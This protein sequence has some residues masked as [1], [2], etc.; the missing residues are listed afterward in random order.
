MR[1]P[2]PGRFAG[3]GGTRSALFEGGEHGRQP[4]TGMDEWF[5]ADKLREWGRPGIGFTTPRH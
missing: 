5:P 3:T 2:V 1:G 4:G